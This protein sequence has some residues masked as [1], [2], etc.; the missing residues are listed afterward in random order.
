MI[1]RKRGGVILLYHRVADVEDDPHLLCVSP[2]NFRSQLNTVRSKLSPYSL[3]EIATEL[4]QDR[5][6]YGFAV[7][8]DD[9]YVD[10]LQNAVP[11]LEE[12]DIPATIFLVGGAIGGDEPFYWDNETRAEDRGRAMTR[13][14]LQRLTAHPL[15]E[16]GAHTLTH[17]HLS[18]LD[19]ESQRWELTESKRMIEE[20]VGEEVEGFAYP[21][22]TPDID[23]TT[24]TLRIARE[25]GYR[26]ACA[27]IPGLIRR[28]A[29]MFALPRVLMRNWS[30]FEMMTRL[31]N[32]FP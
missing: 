18:E 6:P 2:E 26:Y 23:F 27:N 13:S 3:N 21:F 17:P 25:A 4:E 12:L 24:D 19:S 30:N 10:N 11:I 16:I 5:T 28:G 7:S 9:G 20:I 15:V 31:R 14:E 29:E 22:G 8:F 1:F 32:F